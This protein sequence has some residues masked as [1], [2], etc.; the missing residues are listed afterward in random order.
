MSCSRTARILSTSSEDNVTIDFSDL[1]E[2]TG[3]YKA[4]RDVYTALPYLRRGS[5]K[6]SC[7]GD[8]VWTPGSLSKIGS[9]LEGLGL[10]L[11]CS[12]DA[13]G[14]DSCL[15]LLGTHP[16]MPQ[17]LLSLLVRFYMQ[18]DNRNREQMKSMPKL[19]AT[20]IVSAAGELPGFIRERA[21]D[22]N[23]GSGVLWVDPRNS[24]RLE[25]IAADGK[26]FRR[27]IRQKTG[28]TV[29]LVVVHRYDVQHVYNVGGQS[30]RLI[31]LGAPFGI[32]SV[33]R[34]FVSAFRELQ[35]AYASIKRNPNSPTVRTHIRRVFE[36]PFPD[37]VQSVSGALAD[38]IRF[39]RDHVRRESEGVP[40]WRFHYHSCLLERADTD[41]TNLGQFITE[42]LK[43]AFRHT[44]AYT[45]MDRCPS[46]VETATVYSETTK[47]LNDVLNYG[48][49]T[50]RRP[51][52]SGATISATGATASGTTASATGAATSATPS[53]P[54]ELPPTTNGDSQQPSH[55]GSEASQ[56]AYRVLK[57]KPPTDEERKLPLLVRLWPTLT[58]DARIQLAK[59]LNKEQLD[60]AAAYAYRQYPTDY[61]IMNL[62]SRMV[63]EMEKK[64]GENDTD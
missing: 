37:G 21:L 3:E 32:M 45:D 49:P 12:V 35:R 31:T 44:G 22:E 46:M 5:T 42:A 7:F 59:K 50:P 25:G 27:V 10:G 64:A 43:C 13:Q 15:R 11:S 18:P 20:D 26:V 23:D 17:E 61:E 29:S 33:P 9:A 40:S 4:V 36:W 14:L 28:N 1:R 58:P 6:F 60:A 19:R 16:E 38:V 53:N 47:T 56:Y 30:S 55:A 24:G 51:T 62:A 52:T 57:A 54:T 41:E 34:T 8:G 48:T 39:L 63:V 2:A